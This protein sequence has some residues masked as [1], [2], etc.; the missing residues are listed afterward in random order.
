MAVAR[1]SEALCSYAGRGLAQ[2]E[3]PAETES[4]DYKPVFRV[5]NFLIECGIMPNICGVPTLCGPGFDRHP[6]LRRAGVPG[7]CLTILCRYPISLY[8]EMQM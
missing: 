8:K 6:Q 7:F 2:T 4:G 1:S 5:Q 3:R